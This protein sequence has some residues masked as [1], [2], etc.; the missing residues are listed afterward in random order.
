MITILAWS[1]AIAA[2]L[3]SVTLAG[4]LVAGLARGRATR[5]HLPPRPPIAILVPA[6]D[7]ATT[8]ART[9][10]LIRQQLH[11]GDRL[12]VIADNCTDDTAEVARR[13]GAEVIERFA[14][15]RGKAYAL[16]YG[17]EAIRAAPPAV[18][19]LID[20]D[21]V[22]AP[23]AIAALAAS[24]RAQ[25][26]VVQARYLLE[27][28]IDAS[29]LVR[30]S[31]FA[32]LIKNFIRQRGLQRLCGTA[33]LQGSGMGF[34]WRIF[35]HAPLQSASLV[36]DLEL[37]LELALLGHRIRFEP[38]ARFVSNASSRRATTSQRRRWEHGT[39]GI[40]ATFVPRL[41]AAGLAGRPG[42]LLLAADLTVP[43]LAL[44]VIVQSGIAALLVLAAG[45][46]GAS[47]PAWLQLTA[48]ALAILA[49]ATSWAGFGRLLV[50]MRTL[51]GI[52][53]YIVWK[54]PI[55]GGYLL[56]RQRQWVRTDRAP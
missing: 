44:F 3:P 55:Y 4:E 11:A 7:E 16:A 8:I 19:L 48:F 34:P 23:H 42:L 2:A 30:I 17:R 12:I 35:E 9:L 50:P 31:T 32:F 53:A 52:A 49:L 41:V 43:P 54:L 13:A 18:V 39:L 15:E 10:L 51:P 14:P 40:A 29:P 56:R 25:D 38:R 24:V 6:H 46:I 45:S 36:E 37:G 5:L 47:G 1:A 21:C 22:P 28:G 20:A 27:C 33:L 26:A